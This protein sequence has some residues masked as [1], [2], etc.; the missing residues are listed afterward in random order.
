MPRALNVGMQH[1]TAH[2]VPETFLFRSWAEGLAL[3]EDLLRAGPAALCLMPDHA[4][5]LFPVYDRVAMARI[6]SGYTRWLG[7]HRGEPIRQLWLPHPHPE[8]VK[9][10][11][12]LQ[13]SWRYL[14][15]NPCRAKLAS[16]PLA[17][18]LST[19]LDA[20]GLAISPACNVSKE[21]S[22]FHR[23][24]SADPSVHPE[25]SPLP[26]PS[27]ERGKATWQELVAAVSTLTR[28]LERSIS[29]APN[30]R[31]LLACAAAQVLGWK[32]PPIAARLGVHIGTVRADIRQGHPQVSLV[33]R[34]VGDQRLFSLNGERLDRRPSWRRYL[35]DQPNRRRKENI[36][37]R[38]F[39]S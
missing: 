23:Y 2:A 7:H 38:S 34:V 39:P 37:F 24:V 35:A 30:A 3:W 4:H 12:H 5:G 13:R 10:G 18:P 1:F 11:L 31:R 22:A 19:H 29:R 26:A 15:L 20:C 21:P 25:G 17:W 8:E 32:A 28:T 9:D 16:D 14:H 36:P 27:V 33:V 6:L